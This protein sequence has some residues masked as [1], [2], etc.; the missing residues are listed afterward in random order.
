[1]KTW[2]M[3]GAGCLLALGCT[4]SVMA[5]SKDLAQ[6]RSQLAIEYVKVG[7]LRV[8]LDMANEA[9][10]ADSR[11]APAYLTRAYIYSLLQQDGQ[12]EQNYRQALQ[13]DPAN[14][15]GNNNYG[16]FLCEHNRLRDGMGYFSKALANPLYESPQTAYLNMGRCSAKLGETDKANDSLL[17]AL[18]VAPNF[19]PALKELASL[20]L[21]L[22]NAK[23]AGFYFDRLRQNSQV[24]GPEELWLGIRI[25]RRSGDRNLESDCAAQ[26]R[27]RYPDSKET[28]MLLSGS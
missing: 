27:N 17:M 6:I 10:D 9:V 12:A 22:G 1:M 7:N 28:Q 11:S 15:E 14:P 8:A 19:P 5:A 4:A 23:L 20:H 2:R 3:W 21:D 25:A 13:L 26:L 18:R 24:L 16:L